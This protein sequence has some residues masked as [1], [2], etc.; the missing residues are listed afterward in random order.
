MEFILFSACGSEVGPRP[1]ITASGK[2]TLFSGKTELRLKPSG[3]T[4]AAPVYVSLLAEIKEQRVFP[5]LVNVCPRSDELRSDW[6]RTRFHRPP[7]V[8]SPHTVF[9]CSGG[10]LISQTP[11]S[12]RARAHTPPLLLQ[13]RFNCGGWGR[14]GMSL[15]VNPGGEGVSWIGQTCKISLYPLKKNF[16]NQTDQI[17]Q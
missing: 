3:Q 16:S 6:L 11:P 8:L 15:S 7:H 5:S 14:S 13:V 12:A 4:A 10:G 9:R 17:N 2:L 1:Q